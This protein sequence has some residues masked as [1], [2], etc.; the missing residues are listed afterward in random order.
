MKRPK[1]DLQR[2]VPRYFAEMAIGLT[3]AALVALALIASVGHVPF[4]YQGY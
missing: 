4:I 2:R 1:L 3:L